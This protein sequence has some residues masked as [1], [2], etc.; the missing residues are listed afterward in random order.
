MQIQQLRELA[1]R[2]LQLPVTSAP[3]NVQLP[4]PTASNI[5]GWNESGDNLENYPLSELATSLAFATYRYDTFNGNGSTTQFTLSA[6]P[7]TLG[8]LDVA[9]SGV[10]QVPGTDYTLVAGVLQFTSAPA[11]GTVILARFGEGIASGPSMDSYDVRFRQAGTGAID[12]TV[13][14]KLRDTVS[15]FDFMTAA[16]IA[17]VRSGAP[18]INV[19]P[20]IQAALT[21]GKFVFLPQGTYLINA[22]IDLKS[23]PQAGLIGESFMRTSLKAGASMTSVIDL[24]DTTSTYAG[25][26][27]YKIHDI[28][29]DGNSLATYGMRI[30]FRHQIDARGV[31]VQG[32]GTAFWMADSWMCNFWDCYSHF[33]VNGGFHLEGA[34]HSSTYNQCHVTGANT[35]PAVYVGGTN[36]IDGNSDITFNNLLIDACDFTQIVVEMGVNVNVV[37]FN[38]GYMGEYA[39]NTLGTAAF[40]KVISGK[41][42]FNGSEIFCQDT[43]V[44][45]ETGGGMALFWRANGEAIFQNCSIALHSYDY[46]YHPSSNNVGG[47]TIQD[48]TVVNGVSY[49]TELI[50]GLYNLFPVKNYAY[51]ITP[52]HFGR[53]MAY[54]TFTPSGSFARTFPDTESQKVEALTTGG[55]ASLA[56]VTNTLPNNTNFFLVFLEYS[57]NTNTTLR[58]TSA[59]LGAAIWDAIAVIPTT[60]NTRSTFVGLLATPF[61]LTTT[62]AT[63]ELI[64]QAG[65]AWSAGDYVHV[66]KFSIIPVNDIGYSTLNF[67]F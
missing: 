50:S 14:G 40:V 57:S 29:L 61:F 15:V 24:Y 53:D 38:G 12:R 10:T 20:K 13:E 56:M 36:R 35:A 54:N 42:V 47:L 11:N 58:F 2:S 45:P 52:N 67:E 25:I 49:G 3:T 30:R 43:S 23:Y 17:D 26:A 7:V 60:I 1:S 6:D 44:P 34:N 33:N 5:I 27:E 4:Q 9:I 21:Q 37:T 41:A 62:P 31:Y 22:P 51:K 65:T 48:C 8:N 63:L 28:K 64:K 16:E 32:C 46:L 55:F 59:P 18:V 39:A 66:W 19:Q